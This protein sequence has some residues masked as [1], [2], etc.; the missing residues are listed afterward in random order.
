MAPIFTCDMNGKTRTVCSYNKPGVIKVFTTSF[1]IFYKTV[2]YGHVGN[3]CIL[4]NFWTKSSQKIGQTGVYRWSNNSPPRTLVRKLFA[5]IY[6][7][8]PKHTYKKNYEKSI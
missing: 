2:I 7:H 6:M 4:A 5:K 1:N 8:L 3:E